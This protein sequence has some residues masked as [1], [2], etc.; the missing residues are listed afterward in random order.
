MVHTNDLAPLPPCDENTPLSVE[1]SEKS[2]ALQESPES[3]FLKDGDDEEGD[4]DDGYVVKR[5]NEWFFPHKHTHNDT[6]TTIM[7]STTVTNNFKVIFN[8]SDP[9]EQQQLLHH[10]NNRLTGKCGLEEIAVDEILPSLTTSYRHT[11]PTYYP[12]PLVT[13]ILHRFSSLLSFHFCPILSYPVLLC[14]VLFCS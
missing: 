14:P 3:V 6:T 2:S 9:L 1:S 11:T 8:V 4:V 13:I 5:L 10:Y 12:P 7:N